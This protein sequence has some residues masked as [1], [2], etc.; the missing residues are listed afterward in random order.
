MNK[1]DWLRAIHLDGAE[2]VVR[3]LADAP[4]KINL[5]LKRIARLVA[6]Q[7][8]ATARRKVPQ[9]VIRVRGKD[10][11]KKP[12]LGSSGTLKKSLGSKVIHNKKSGRITLLVG[13][14]KKQGR[15]VL[16][17]TGTKE[18]FVNPSRYAHLVEK[19]AKIRIY[20]RGRSIRTKAQPFL[21]PAYYQ[22]RNVV[23]D[24]TSRVIQETLASL[25]NKGKGGS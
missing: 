10:G 20:G 18:V 9:R 25:E 12:T 2:Q 24:I 19:G 14:R 16:D 15:M 4:G 13:P 22:A 17:S 6:T 3:A 5:A 21:K 8:L 11:K 23:D 7:A 1:R